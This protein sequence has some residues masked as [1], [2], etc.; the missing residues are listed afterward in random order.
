MIRENYKKL[1]F[2]TIIRTNVALEEAVMNGVDIFAYDSKSN[3]AKDYKNVCNEII[4][5][6]Q[7]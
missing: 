6:K 2:K 3:G 4:K 7:W 5:T 1:V